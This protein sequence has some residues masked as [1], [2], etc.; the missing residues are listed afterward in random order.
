MEPW[1]IVLTTLALVIVSLLIIIVVRA[2]NFKSKQLA[3]SDK[4]AYPVNT[5][6][7][8]AR[9]SEAVRFQTVSHIDKSRMDFKEFSRFH[10][11]LE[12]SFPLIFSRLEKKVINGYNLLFIWKGSDPQKKPV[13]L[14]AHQDVVPASGEGWKY[15]PFSGEIVDGYVWGRGTLDDK[16]CLLSIMEAIEFLLSEGYRPSSSIFLASGFDEEVGGI[17][18]AGK[19]AAYLRSENIHFEYIIDE[20]LVITRGAVPGVNDWVALI[21]IAEKGYVSLELSAE[22]KGGHAANPPPQTSVGIIAAAI[23]KLQKNPFPVRM[24]SPAAALFKYLGPE[25]PF[26]SRLVFANMWLFGSMVKKRMAAMQTTSASVRTTIAPT[27]FRGSPQDNILPTVAAAVVNFRIL[28]GESIQSV[29]QRVKTVINDPR[30]MIRPLPNNL[31]DPSPVA[32][33]SSPAYG[34]INRTIREVTGKTLVTPALVQGRTDSIYYIDLAP[35]CYRFVPARV[36]IEEISAPHGVNERVAVDN[37]A[38][39]INFYIRLLHNSCD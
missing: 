3:V 37:Y 38:E 11:Y 27:M 8:V 12:K 2:F 30:I 17:E 31:F 22:Q 25:M 9:L 26:A 1:A 33:D 4:I 15:P 32:S 7:A 18:G 16:G 20:G 14:L 13:L 19:I 21:G 35:C 23:D 5:E 28:Q 34:I 29:I 10:E 36:P 24:T 39:M 6:G